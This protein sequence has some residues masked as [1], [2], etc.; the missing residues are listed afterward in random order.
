LTKKKKT[1]KEKTNYP[2]SKDRRKETRNVHIINDKSS[3]RDIELA[4]SDLENF[5][6]DSL[7]KHHG[8]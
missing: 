6:L 3:N 1:I 5:F 8:F 4:K 2:P 7:E